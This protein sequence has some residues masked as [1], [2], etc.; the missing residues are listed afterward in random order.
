MKYVT[1]I[2]T[3]VLLFGCNNVYKGI[4][5]RSKVPAPIGVGAKTVRALPE[6]VQGFYLKSDAGFQLHPTVDDTIFLGK[7]YVRIEIEGEKVFYSEVIAAKVDDFNKAFKNYSI[8]LTNNHLTI[9]NNTLNEELHRISG[10]TDSKLK[11]RKKKLIKYFSENSIASV[12]PIQKVDDFVI[13]DSKLIHFFDLSKQTI[14]NF[15]GGGSQCHDDRTFDIQLKKYQDYYCLNI[16]FGKVAGGWT[17]III[18]PDPELRRFTLSYIND[19]Y[20]NRNI[21]LFEQNIGLEIVP[22]S[23]TEEHFDFLYNPSEASID[24]LVHLDSAMHHEVYEKEM[25][26]D[27]TEFFVL[28]KVFN[29]KYWYVYSIAGLALLIIGLLS[30]FPLKYL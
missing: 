9:F 26:P 27:D 13:L 3:S 28:E 25:R 10:M 24:Y 2:L 29:P 15:S 20:I 8:V 30:F 23:S 12:L 16:D 17:N 19:G 1:F 14:Y 18:H 21:E 6:T 22:T 4:E 7:E 5:T 11:E